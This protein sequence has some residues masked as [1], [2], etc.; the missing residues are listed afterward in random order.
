VVGDTV[1]ITNRLTRTLKHYFPHV[2]SWGQEKDTAIFCDCLSR[3]PPLKAGQ[4]ARR[5][6]LETFFR[7]HHV[8]Y[9]DVITQRIE[10]I[11]SAL[12][13]T[14]DAGVLAPKALLVQA[15]GAQLRVTW[16]AIAA[17]D[18]AIAQYAQRQPD[19]PLCQALPGA[20]PGFAPRLL[21]ACGE[22]RERSAS[23]EELQKYAGI[24]PVTERR[25]KT[26]WGHWRLQCPKCLR[27]TFGEWAAKS[28]RH[29]VWA[30]LYYQQQRDTGTTPQAAVRALAFKWL[31]IL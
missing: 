30:Q 7:A 27:Q 10:A 13:L 2:L 3:W 9:A 23:A 16:K 24:A 19:F 11:T 6:P 20:G 5:S 14:T 31:R 15:L 25:G 1:R 21:V 17:V 28:I 29:A 22:Q 26:S 18:P 12:P 4:R 8:R